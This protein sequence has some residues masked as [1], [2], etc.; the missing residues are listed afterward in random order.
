MAPFFYHAGVVQIELGVP[1]E[2]IETLSA[3]VQSRRELRTDSAVVVESGHRR[4]SGRGMRADFGGERVEL[5]NDVQVE[6]APES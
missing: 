5:L 1:A 3:L 4:A 2:V 6:Y